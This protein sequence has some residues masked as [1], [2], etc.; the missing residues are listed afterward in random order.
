MFEGSLF[1]EENSLVA[2]NCIVK[3]GVRGT[4]GCIH[5]FESINAFK[6]V[7][8]VMFCRAGKICGAP[9]LNL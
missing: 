9:A 6:S 7:F 5:A 4:V 2:S 3:T 1:H 8:V